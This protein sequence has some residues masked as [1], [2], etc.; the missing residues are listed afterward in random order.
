MATTYRGVTLPNCRLTFGT[1]P[2][3]WQ[4]E[5]LPMTD[6]EIVFP[7]GKAGGE[8]TAQGHI[9]DLSG[10]VVY[11]SYAIMAALDLRAGGDLVIVGIGTYNDV[12]IEGGIKFGPF[13]TYP[14]PA[15]AGQ[16]LKGCAY[17]MKFRL[18]NP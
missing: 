3:V 7:M 14:N 5:R 12:I 15:S 18:P 1:P 8:V 17:S 13:A 16:T 4:I 2:Q 6:G 10:T 11:P 9:R